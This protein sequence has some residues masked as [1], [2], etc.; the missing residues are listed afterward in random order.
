MNIMSI[1]KI[2]VDFRK[3]FILKSIIVTIYCNVIYLS[4]LVHSNNIM[5]INKLF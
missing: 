5:S 4:K 2:S 1:N 3:N